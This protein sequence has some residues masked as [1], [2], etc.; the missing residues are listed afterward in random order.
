MSMTKY[1]AVMMLDRLD[2]SDPESAHG[3]AEDILM[4][5]LKAN[6]FPEVAEAFEKAR[7]RVGFWYA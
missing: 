1:D 5:F 6:E 7:D 2:D 3:E 4:A